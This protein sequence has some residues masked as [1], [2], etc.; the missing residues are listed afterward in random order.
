MINVR[1]FA[2]YANQAFGLVLIRH[3]F[4]GEVDS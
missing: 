4:L 1:G 3:C 2:F